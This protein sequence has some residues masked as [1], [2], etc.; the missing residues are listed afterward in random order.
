MN[1]KQNKRNDLYHGNVGACRVQLREGIGCFDEFDVSLDRS[2][3]VGV[4]G[5]LLLNF[6]HELLQIVRS[7]SPALNL[8]ILSSYFGTRGQFN[9]QSEIVVQVVPRVQHRKAYLNNSSLHVYPLIHLQS[10][11]LCF[12]FLFVLVEVNVEASVCV[13]SIVTHMG[14][15]N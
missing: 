13:G 1:Q 5:I 14:T 6:Q 10:F 4:L 7:K 8:L 11:E 3:I 9:Y 2:R 12:G 15:D